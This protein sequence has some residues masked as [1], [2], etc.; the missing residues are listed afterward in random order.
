MYNAVHYKLPLV[1]LQER[2]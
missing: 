2:W 1:L